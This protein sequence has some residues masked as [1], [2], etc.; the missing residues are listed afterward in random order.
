MKYTEDQINKM[1]ENHKNPF[2][3]YSETIKPRPGFDALMKR[4]PANWDD[5]KKIVKSQLPE[6]DQKFIDSLQV[7]DSIN[8]FDKRNAKPFDNFVGKMP[9]YFI[10]RMENNRKYVI[11]TEGYDYIRY[12]V[13]IV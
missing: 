13:E 4:K 6:E 8:V 1:F 11:R 10:L 9:D 3:V 5:T 7:A 12:M 2:L